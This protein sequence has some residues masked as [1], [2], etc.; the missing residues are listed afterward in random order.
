MRRLRERG[1]SPRVF[2]RRP[3]APGS[4]AKGLD[5]V[6]GSLGEPEAVDR[7]VAGVEVVY[8]VGAAM[9]GWRED[10]EAG[11]VWGTRNIIDAC[12]RHRVKRLVYVS[13]LGVLDHAGHEDG[14]IVDEESPVEPNPDLRGLYTQTKLEAE[15]MVLAATKERGLDAVIVR[16]GQI[17]GPGAEK[18]TP[19][20]VIKLA[21][22]WIVAGNGKRML[23][24]VYIEDVVDGS[25]GRRNGAGG[26]RPDYSSDRSDAVIAKRVSEVVQA[27]AGKNADPPHSGRVSDVR[28]VDVRRA[29]EAC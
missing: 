19:N 17:F 27:G 22:Q 21:G 18:V 26:S 25:A 24:A 29:F 16:P 28:G 14:V 13:S 2:L 10:F 5:A 12:L 3:A 11:T 6:Y 20:G 4:A 9:K 15:R 23:P 7:A 8:H 1:E